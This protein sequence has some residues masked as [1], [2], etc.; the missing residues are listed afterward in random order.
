M[1]L[2]QMWVCFLLRLV[3]GFLFSSKTA[4]S[5]IDLPTKALPDVSWLSF[6]GINSFSFITIL[7]GN[8]ECAGVI[9]MMTN[10]L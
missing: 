1:A 5:E 3:H 10:G 6:Q 9:K 4:I 7:I 2:G 8:R